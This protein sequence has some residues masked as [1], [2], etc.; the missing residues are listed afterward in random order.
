MDA[1]S[2]A[3]RER[4]P[5]WAWVAFGGAFLVL[6]PLWLI[7]T[8][9]VLQLTPQEWIDER[10]W[11]VVWSLGG[12]RGAIALIAFLG[13]VGVVLLAAGLVGWIAT[14]RKR[15]ARAALDAAVD[16]EA[17][18]P[19]VTLRTGTIETYDPRRDA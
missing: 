4:L 12:A 5:G 3:A 16:D 7:L 11:F 1:T 15:R 10:P 2:R 13:I 9:A 14:A 6:G 8:A 19:G 18:L 17:V